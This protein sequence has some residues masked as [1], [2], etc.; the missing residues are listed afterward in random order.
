MSASNNLSKTIPPKTKWSA[1]DEVPRARLW[2]GVIIALIGLFIF[3]LGVKPEWFKL[4][5]SPGVG[6]AQITVFLFGLGIIC[7][8]GLIGLLSFWRG[9]ERTIVSDIGMRL[10][11]T[12]YVISIFAGMADILGFGSQ[13]PPQTPYFGPLQ[14]TGVLV[15]QIV[16]AIGFLMLY[17]FR[18]PGNTAAQSRE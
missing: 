1:E 7:S 13:P 9:G 15:G 10:I 8:G 5:R 17:P 14:A 12:G 11:G 16:I 6:F 18:R 3:T 2:A 4:D